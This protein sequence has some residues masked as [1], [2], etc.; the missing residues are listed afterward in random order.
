M[1]TTYENLSTRA[2]SKYNGIQASTGNAPRNRLLVALAGPPGSGKTT[3]ANHVAARINSQLNL[4]HGA[5]VVSIDGFHL[6]RSVLDA[7]P[8]SEEAH[9]RRGAHWT[10]DAAA[11][12]SFIRKTRDFSG[13]LHAP[14]FDHAVKDPTANGLSIPEETAILIFEGLY[15]L[16]DLEPW[17]EIAECV[18]EKWFVNVEPERAR[19]RVAERHVRAGI[20]PDFKSALRRVDKNDAINGRWI[21]EKRGSCDV[22]VESMEER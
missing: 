2:I 12:V 4:C 17:R 13:T 15:L 19:H 21:C 3:I 18:D 8:N 14:T 7:L 22:L 6:P 5:L 16:C 9:I 10:F 11:A 20:E 1:E